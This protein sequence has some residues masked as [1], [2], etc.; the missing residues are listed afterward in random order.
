MQ[1]EVPP[2]PRLVGLHVRLL[3]VGELVPDPV[4]VP[5]T[6]VTVIAPPLTVAPSVLV[7]LMVVLETPDAIVTLTTATTPFCMTFEFNPASRQ[8]YDPELDEQLIDFPAALALVPATALIETMSLGVYVNA[9]C[10]PAGS[11]PLGELSV[12]FKLTLP[13]ESAVP[14]A[15][16][17]VSW[18]N[19]RVE[20]S[21]NN[22]SADT[23][24]TPETRK[25]LKLPNTAT[26]LPQE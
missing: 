5:P 21:R 6:P 3:S 2:D 18:A 25:R 17:S 7:R 20:E 19:P 4:I 14:E 24:D 22:E 11:L 16:V 13:P 26:N 1:V 10:R 23:N 12:R 8:K 9:H 15:N